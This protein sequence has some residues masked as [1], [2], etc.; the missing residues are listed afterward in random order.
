[1]MPFN[2][3]SLLHSKYNFAVIQV[4]SSQYHLTLI[5]GVKMINHHFKSARS[6]SLKEM[7]EAT[8]QKSGGDEG[9]Y[10]L[11]IVL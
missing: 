10:R 7:I 8:L 5:L 2:A 3:L 4:I 9:S 11:F 1:M 6:A